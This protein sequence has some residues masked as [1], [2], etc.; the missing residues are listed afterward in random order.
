MHTRLT[1]KL[2]LATLLMFGFGYA[3]VPLYDVLC[4]I[5][6]INGKTAS[7]AATAATGEIDS[8]RTVTLELVAYPFPGFEGRFAPVVQ[9]IKVHPG[10]LSRTHFNV[11]NSADSARVLQAVPSVTPGLGA[12]YLH[13][14]ECFCFQQQHLALGEKAQLPLY[15]YVDQ[16]LPAELHTLTLSYTLY[17][18]TRA[19]GQGDQNG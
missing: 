9:R 8:S 1:L 2:V 16:A 18:V 14:T 11:E 4:R 12:R 5:T 3:L 15:F 10:E 13:K 7:V 19:A 6:G 17:D